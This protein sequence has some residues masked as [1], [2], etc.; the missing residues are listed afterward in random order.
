MKPVLGKLFLIVTILF[1]TYSYL[2]VDPVSA[3]IT[4][5]TPLVEFTGGTRD[6]YTSLGGDI[7]G[8]GYDDLIIGVPGYNA[9]GKAYIFFGNNN[10]SSQNYTAADITINGQAAPDE[11]G[12]AV[13]LSGD[14][15][16]DGFNDI[17]VGANQN[18][19]G[20]SQAGRAYI[21]Y[22]KSTFGATI[23]AASADVIYTG[24]AVDDFL[25]KDLASA[26]DVNNDGY[27]DVIV[28]A[29]F[30]DDA[31]SNFGAA[32][33]FYGGSSMASKNLKTGD[34][35]DITFYGSATWS[36]FGTNVFSAGDV[37]GD[38]FTDVV[39]AGN[40]T[41]YV[42]FGG[43][44]MDNTAD[45]TISG[46]IAVASD[47][48]DQA[49]DINRDGYNDLIL[50]DF[51]SDKSY[52]YYGGSSMDAV[53]DVTLTGNEPL[54]SRFGEVNAFGGDFNN[55]SYSDV[56]VGDMVYDSNKGKVYIF[57]SNPLLN[58]KNSSL[59]SSNAPST[60]LHH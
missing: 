17:L 14:F 38:G 59:S 2:L 23:A 28:G 36:S 43:S 57:F 5:L 27:D 15:N 52:I 12:N 30:N 21:F 48:F 60:A 33:I 41:A 35:A 24:K 20:G 50:G 1:C 6:I 49:G 54:T 46:I 11:F 10:P 25:G 9:A 34:T 18:G 13:D 26:G 19:A 55:D 8:D 45:V 29:I 51:T 58:D 39:S 40:F 47:A 42:Y 3:A 53:V 44:T 37:N 22:G 7:N 31:G 32:Y 4:N 16:N 56:I